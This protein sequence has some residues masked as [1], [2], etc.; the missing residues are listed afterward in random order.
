MRGPVRAPGAT[1]ALLA[2]ALL[3]AACGGGGPRGEDVGK[4]GEALARYPGTREQILAYYGSQGS[5]EPG[6]NCGRGTIDKIDASRVVSDTPV[7]VVLAVTYRFTAAPLAVS[8]A[9]CAGTSTRYFTFDR[10]A[11]GK[12]TLAEM[13]D[14][15]P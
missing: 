5:G 11:D 7:E 4:D 10:E 9:R 8:G 2:A 1:G 15:S 13:A 6:F 3:L 12:L 14:E